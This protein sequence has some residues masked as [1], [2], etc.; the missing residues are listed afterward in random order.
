MVYAMVSEAPGLF[1]GD[2]RGADARCDFCDSPVRPISALARHGCAECESCGCVVCLPRP[3]LSAA[4]EQYQKA[5]YYAG[6]YTVGELGAQL[7]SHRDLARRLRRTIGPGG[8]VLE[9]G[10]AAGALLA[11]L[12]DERLSATGI[13]V[14]AAAV[15]QARSNFGVDA[16]QALVEDHMFPIDL[17]ALVALH[18][19]EHLVRPALLLRKAA[20]AVRRGGVL[21]LEVPDYGARMRHQMGEGWPYFLPGEHLQHFDESSLRRLLEWYGF[22]LF[23]VERLGGL[24]M[25][26]PGHGTEGVGAAQGVVEPPPGWRRRLYRARHGVYRIPGGR[27]LVRTVNELIGYRILHR[28][29]YLRVWGRRR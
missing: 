26:Q 5:D 4:A 21:V 7:A 12:R 10:C 17:D 14:S 15:S 19:I 20:T 28:N 13:D 1:V 3:T 22:Q 25:L 24:G 16:H 9:V 23:R 11:A 6:K 27:A 18:V 8:R 2:R 29:A